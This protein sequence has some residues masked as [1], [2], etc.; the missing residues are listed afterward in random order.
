M[1][2]AL[3][4]KAGRR[5]AFP[6]RTRYSGKSSVLTHLPLRGQRRD[7]GRTVEKCAPSPASLF[8]SIDAYA[9]EHLK[10]AAKVSGLGVQRQ[11]KPATHLNH[12][13]GPYLY[14][15]RH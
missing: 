12:R 8:H 5:C 4:T 11:L 1:S 15:Y 2:G 7:R 6:Y 9:K 10:Q 13:H 14:D 3:L